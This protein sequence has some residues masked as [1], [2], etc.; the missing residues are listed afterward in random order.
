MVQELTFAM[1]AHVLKSTQ[2]GPNPYITI[3][4][5]FFEQSFG[6]RKALLRSSALFPDQTWLRS[7]TGDGE[8]RPNT[9]RTRSSTRAAS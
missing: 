3:I 2:D 4:L 1:L 7:L 6:I 9:R 5:T 8:Y